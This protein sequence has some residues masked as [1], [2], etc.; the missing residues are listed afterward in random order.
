VLLPLFEEDG[1]HG[2]DRAALALEADDDDAVAWLSVTAVC[3]ERDPEDGRA[4]A[5]T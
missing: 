5:S 4:S 3:R 1:S 2:R